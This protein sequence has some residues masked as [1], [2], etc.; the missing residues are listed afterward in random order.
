[1]SKK[2]QTI[3]DYL[4]DYSNL[5]I[6]EVISELSSS[7]Q[8]LI[9]ERYGDDLYNPE[10]S[11]EWNELKSAE[12]CG[13]LMPKIK[14]L[15]KEK[16]NTLK[17]DK[18]LEDISKNAKSFDYTLFLEI[19]KSG[20]TN[21][22]ICQELGIEPT[23]LAE[24][25][26]KLR[27]MGFKCDRKYY[28]DGSIK[29][30]KLCSFKELPIN[31]LVS[32]KAII[33]E[34][35]ENDMK[36]LVIS[37]LHFGNELER[38]DLVYKAY[39]YCIKNNIHIILCTGDMVDGS[40]SRGEQRISELALQ[41][42]YFIKNYPYDRNILTFGVAGNHDASVFKKIALDIA[43]VCQNY[44]HDII[45]GGYNNFEVDIKNDNILLYHPIPNGFQAD[46]KAPIILF[47]HTHQYSTAF[48]DNVLNV[49]V[50][51]LSNIITSM[52][53]ALELSLHF[54]KG[55]I[56]EALVK[57]IYFGQEDVVLNESNFDFSRLV[58]VE[59]IRNIEMFRPESME[60]AK[61]LEKKNERLS[62]VEKFYR[63]YGVKINK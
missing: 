48:K 9:R 5:E 52:P 53:S 11:F 56:D 27:M 16:K 6:D 17:V 32:K 41:V 43:Q 51:S 59:P 28:S 45:I 31:S 54:S 4:S 3:Y 37:D 26:L 49:K 61:V 23:Q 24:E 21:N 57:Q 44:R 15:L 1:M 8:K 25:L 7:E 58:T 55:Y 60:M 2:L 40:F 34:F 13:N 20:K 46:I 14:R 47:G 33:T 22:E 36:L 38:V 63:K 18:K 62:Q 42:E 30:K 50:P 29:Y 39:N 19:L 12:F 10:P 35:K